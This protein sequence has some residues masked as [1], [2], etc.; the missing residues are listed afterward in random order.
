LGAQDGH[1]R[2]RVVMQALVSRRNL[3]ELDLREAVS[4]RGAIDPDE[5]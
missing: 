1:P 4:F 2:L 3:I 5:R